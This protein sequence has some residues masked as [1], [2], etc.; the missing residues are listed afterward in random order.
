MKKNHLIALVIALL[1]LAFPFR[2]AYL[3]HELPTL[4]RLGAFLFTLFGFAVAGGVAGAVKVKVTPKT[5]VAHPVNTEAH[6]N[7]L[8]AH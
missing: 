8:A 7:Y 1:V 3:E 6:E 4:T 5:K 2:W